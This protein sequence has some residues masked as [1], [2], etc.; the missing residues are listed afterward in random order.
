MKE[1]YSGLGEN[2]DEGDEFD[3]DEDYLL[4]ESE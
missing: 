3:G 1:Y 4:S 2:N